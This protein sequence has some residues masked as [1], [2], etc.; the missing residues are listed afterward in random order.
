MLCVWDKLKLSDDITENLNPGMT[1][2]R[3]RNEFLTAQG[4]S[5]TLHKYEWKY[6]L[7]TGTGTSDH[8]FHLM[9][10]L[11][12]GGSG[13]P[14]I[15]LD[16]IAGN[17]SITDLDP[18]R[19][20]KNPA[21]PS[22]GLDEFEGKTTVHSVEVTYGDTDGSFKYTVTDG[23]KTLLTYNVT[24]NTGEDA[25]IKFGTYRRVVD[26]MTVVRAAVGDFTGS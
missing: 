3:Q 26:G 2:A 8:F 25:S 21:C 23:S 15:T 6:Y 20:C 22:T 18:S 4:A 7:A 12:R 24:G 11:T 16:A 14:V 5:G 10:L 13:G 17:I 9:Q 1:P 19:D